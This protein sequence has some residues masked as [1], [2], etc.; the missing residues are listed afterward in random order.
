MITLDDQNKIR[1]KICGSEFLIKAEESG[2]Y[3]KRIAKSV[4]TRINDFAKA[5]QMSTSMASILAALNYCDELEK[6]HKIT[7]ELIRKAD[8]C[9]AAVKRCTHTIEHLTKENEQLRDEKEGLHKVM[10]ELREELKQAKQPASS[11]NYYNQSKPKTAQ[12]F[13][14]NK[15]TNI[16]NPKNN[17]IPKNNPSSLAGQDGVITFFDEKNT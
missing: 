5:P 8:E 15:P 11:N 6:Q 3:I 17:F 16:N 13:I 1:I 9:E 10:D 7:N 14:P 2:E 12:K 4:D